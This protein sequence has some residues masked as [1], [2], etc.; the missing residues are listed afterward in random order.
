MI[1]HLEREYRNS[2]M[3]WKMGMVINYLRTIFFELLLLGRKES[4]QNILKPIQLVCIFSP[5]LPYFPYTFNCLLLLELYLSVVQIWAVK[6]FTKFLI[7]KPDNSFF[8]RFQESEELQ[9]GG[10]DPWHEQDTEARLSVSLYTEC[11]FIKSFDRI[12]FLIGFWM[13][14]F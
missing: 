13:F 4:I 14:L 8:L 12:G 10:R 3:W 5:V 2:K 6:D 7:L 9:L 11:S 1:F